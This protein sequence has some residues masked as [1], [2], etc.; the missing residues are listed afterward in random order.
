M[1]T[2]RREDIYALR[3][4]PAALLERARR[5]PRLRIRGDT[6]FFDDGPRFQGFRPAPALAERIAQ[7]AHGLERAVGVH[8]R[9]TDNVQA[10]QR[11]PLEGYLA[12]LAAE[13]R[14]DPATT[15]FVATDDPEVL[16][17]LKAEHGRTVRHTVPRSLDRNTPEAIEDALVD[18]WCLSS[19]RK[20]I[21]SAASTFTETAWQLRGI[22]CTVID[23]RAAPGQGR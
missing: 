12:A 9:R 16:E 13:R 4:D 5:A 19:C 8:V 10:R 14:A 22:P 6:R 2:W 21:G 17:R 15:F 11:S 20:L 3:P 7:A 18:L 23:V 1:E